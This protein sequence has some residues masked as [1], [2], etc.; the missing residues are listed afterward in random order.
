MIEIDCIMIQTS[1]EFLPTWNSCKDIKGSTESCFDDPR[2][3]ILCEDAL[4]WFMDRYSS[5]S[6]IAGLQ[7]DKFDVIIM[8]ALDPQDDIPFAEAL[9][10][11]DAFTQ[12]LYNALT[13][14]GIVVMQL[15]V[16]PDLEDTADQYSKSKNR[17][18]LTNGLSIIG[19]DSLHAYE[20][21]H[22]GFSD[23]WSFLVACKTFGCR[24]RWYTNSAAI[25][26]DIRRRI[27]PTFSGLPALKYFDGSTMSVYHIPS[28]P[29][30]VI[31]CRQDSPP[32]EC[33]TLQG[34]DPSIPNIPESSFEV[35]QITRGS[36]SRVGLFSKVD[37]SRGS[38]IVQEKSSNSVHFFPTTTNLIYRTA[39]LD[40]LAKYHL[41]GLLTIFDRY[42]FENNLFGSTGYDMHSSILSLVNHGCNGTYNIGSD[43]EESITEETA[44]AEN[45]PYGHSARQY[46]KGRWE[47][48]FNPIVERHLQHLIGGYDV[49]IRDIAK[50]EEVLE[51]VLSDI[52]TEEDWKYWVDRLQKI[53]QAEHISSMS[54][55]T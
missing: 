35:K 34:Y 16:T 39:E 14:D 24:E 26:L 2:A 21:S 8:D 7:E 51:N 22:C 30:E 12:S 23:P 45:L 28:K 13:D 44:D 53:C 11:N 3:E 37:I 31:Y 46:S 52:N 25:D 6:T 10:N 47:N 1:R 41:K 29:S 17:A 48:V 32:K 50:G 42:A 55:T 40:P 4:S 36:S 54:Q 15:G 18:K 20:E 27:L 5:E 38:M 33:A 9:Y 49:A 19:F 43:D